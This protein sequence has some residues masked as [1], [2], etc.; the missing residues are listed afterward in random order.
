MNLSLSDLLIINEEIESPHHYAAKIKNIDRYYGY[1]SWAEVLMRSGNTLSKEKAEDILKELTIEFQSRPEAYIKLWYFYYSTKDFISSLSVAETAF[2]KLA[3]SS[4]EYSVIINL[5]YARSLFKLEKYRSCFELLQM[6]Y[7]QNSQY[8]VYLYHYGRMCLKSKDSVFLGSAIGALEE[9]LKICNF[10]RHGSVYYWLM[11]GYM[12]GGDKVQAYK[13][14][15]AGIGLLTNTIEKHGLSFGDKNY[16]QKVVH[17]INEMKNVAKDLHMDILNMEILD[18]IIENKDQGKYEEAKLHCKNIS[19]FDKVEGA[20]FN[21]KLLLAMGNIDGAM[22][23][24]YKSLSLKSLQMKS[25]FMLADVL[26][27][28]QRHGELEKICKDMM[29]RCKSPMIPVQVWIKTHMVYIKC[30]LYRKAYEKAILVL[31]SLAQVQPSPFI[32]DLEYTRNLQFATSKDHLV[33]LFE[34]Y[35]RDSLLGDGDIQNTIFCRAKLLC[36]RRNLSSMVIESDSDGEI[37]SAL[38]EINENY[39]NIGSR[40]PEP[41]PKARLSKTPG[42]DAVNTGF[43]VSISYK[44]LYKIGKIAAMNKICIEDG[45]CAMHDFLN[46]HHYWMRE[47]IESDEIMQVKG[48]YWLAV[49]LFLKGDMEQAVHIFKDIMSMLFQLNMQKMSQQI[50]VYMKEY[51]NIVSGGV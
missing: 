16:E 10:Y 8:S 3:E 39:L 20:I 11:I 44:F 26:V 9:C 13:Y 34:N 50:L 6:M 42:G 47:G 32:P 18:K 2:L 27:K 31:K 5:N 21:Y 43:S 41:L 19:K 12:T 37:I 22:G 33:N 4:A 28:T 1:L 7:T 38:E 35:K 24:L 29:K 49:L 48:S 46:I 30:L 45:Y 15:K 25:F 23:V 40:A 36:S 14:A 17:K 51:E